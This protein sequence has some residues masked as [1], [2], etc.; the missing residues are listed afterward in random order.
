MLRQRIA[1]YSKMSGCNLQAPAY[2]IKI[3]T[4]PKHIRQNLSQQLVLEKCFFS[5][6]QQDKTD[7][8]NEVH[9]KLLAND[10]VQRYVSLASDI[11]IVL[12]FKVPKF[13]LSLI[14]FLEH[15][16]T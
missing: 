15:K 11:D 9:L 2:N 14:D 6:C 16:Y 7:S 4:N 8:R 13:L 5:L 10:I 3:K 1:C 12:L